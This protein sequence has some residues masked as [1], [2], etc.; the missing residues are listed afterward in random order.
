MMVYNKIISTED[1]NKKKYFASKIEI[2]EIRSNET[3]LKWKV[4]SKANKLGHKIWGKEFTVNKLSEDMG[5]PIT[6]TKRCLSLDNATAKNWDRV[7][8]KEISAFKLA[9]I[10][11]TK[12][13]TFQDEV[14]EAVVSKNLST[15]QIKAFKP[16][17]IKD[18]TKWKH[19]KAVEQGYSRENAA[20]GALNNWISRGSIFMLMPISSIGKKHKEEFMESLKLLHIKIGRYIDND[21][22]IL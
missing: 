3:L 9:M 2:D 11:M 12:G 21:G 22:E 1:A 5:L 8:T 19:E 17:N 13:Q 20:K 14:V 18:V 15:S 16:K 6:T 10:C 7:R 4:L